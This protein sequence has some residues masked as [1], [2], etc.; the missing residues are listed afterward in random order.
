MD[1]FCTWSSLPINLIGHKC[2]QNYFFTKISF[3]ASPIFLTKKF[4]ANLDSFL[5]TFIWNG[6]QPRIARTSIQAA[7]AV[8]GLACLNLR[9]HF[10]ASQLIYIHDWLQSD[11]QMP[12]PSYWPFLNL[13]LYY[14]MNCIDQ[15]DQGAP[16]VPLWRFAL[17]LGGREE[18]RWHN[19]SQVSHHRLHC[20]RTPTSLS[21]G[22]PDANWWARF[23]NHTYFPHSWGEYAIIFW[24]G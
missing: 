20:G 15:G 10:L 1:K 19:P 18:K 8:G 4:F 23:G 2:I 22:Q 3:R 7:K 11:P 6:C 21:S 17:W 14:E 24:S 9:H 13:L 12:L 16:D 5:S